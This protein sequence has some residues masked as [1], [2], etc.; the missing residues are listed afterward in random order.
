MEEKKANPYGIVLDGRMDEAVWETAE[1]HKGFVTLSPTG[2]VP[3]PVDT[4]FKVLTFPDRIFIG[5][6]CLEPTGME[7][8]LASRYRKN[9][10]TGHAVELF[11]HLPAII[12]SSI[13]SWSPSTTMI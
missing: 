1:T 12:M 6:K 7:D 3:A 10:Y 4:E 11:Y 13:S 8:V 2:G 5:V 9:S